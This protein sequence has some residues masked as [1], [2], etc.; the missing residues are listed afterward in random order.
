MHQR[1]HNLL[2]GVGGP[3]TGPDVG[4]GEAAFPRQQEPHSRLVYL[5]DALNAL[6][7]TYRKYGWCECET[8]LALCYHRCLFIYIFSLSLS[9][10]SIFGELE[11]AEGGKQFPCFRD[12]KH[13][14]C[15]GKDRKYC[16]LEG[17]LNN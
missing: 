15:A 12:W 1:V 5:R 11:E 10:R 7:H 9:A 17:N 14:A 4:R 6:M 8:V 2:L 3:L 13:S 16:S